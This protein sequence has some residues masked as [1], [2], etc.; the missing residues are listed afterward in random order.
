MADES[1]RRPAVAV[2]LGRD[3]GMRG[4]DL[5]LR[6]AL[7]GEREIFDFLR[8]TEDATDGAAAFAAKRTPVWRGR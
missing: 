7:D 1:V 4:V 2:E 8:S 6:A 5:R 3:A